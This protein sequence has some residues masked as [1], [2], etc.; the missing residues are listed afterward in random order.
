MKR[1]SPL[2]A[3]RRFHL[4]GLSVDGSK[5][6]AVDFG[7]S[8]VSTGAKVMTDT[9]L[10]GVVWTLG[11]GYAVLQGRP[12][13]LDV[14]G[15]LRYLS[16]EASTDWNVALTVTGPSGANTV[17]RS[18]SVSE[19]GELWDGIVGV[20]GR[21][22]LGQSN[23]SI[24]YYCDMGTGSSDLTWQGMLGIEYTYKVDQRDARVPASFL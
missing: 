22:L 23:W 2:G 19:R 12:L 18:G 7:G 3:V 20:K 10:T 6:K 4:P 14:F 1:A 11:A 21:F 8:L 15:G 17:V 5:V 16:L 24:P 13:A 9:T